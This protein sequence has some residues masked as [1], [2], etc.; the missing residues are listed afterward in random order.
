MNAFTESFMDE[1]FNELHHVPSTQHEEQ[2]V[3]LELCHVRIFVSLSVLVIE[4][5]QAL[6]LGVP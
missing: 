1:A 4:P 5:G 6:L 3:N 2:A